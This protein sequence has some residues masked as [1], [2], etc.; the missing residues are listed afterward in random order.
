M[1]FEAG[2]DALAVFV[3]SPVYSCWIHVNEEVG[4]KGLDL[5]PDVLRTTD[6]AGCPIA[7][8]LDDLSWPSRESYT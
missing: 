4:V 2:R 8:S 7:W 1:C 5:L 6:C 3:L